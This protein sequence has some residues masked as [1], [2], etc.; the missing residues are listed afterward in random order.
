MEARKARK[1][2]NCFACGA[3]ARDLVSLFHAGTA[4]LRPQHYAQRCRQAA[5]PALEEQIEF[6]L[7]YFIQF[8]KTTL[9]NAPHQ[10]QI[11]TEIV[12]NELIAHSGNTFPRHCLMPRGH[13]S[14]E[15]FHRL[16][17]NFQIPN[18]RILSFAILKKSILPVFRIFANHLYRIANM[19]QIDLGILFQIATAS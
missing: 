10:L 19:C 14:R 4:Y 9:D 18:H 13:F 8:V 1:E 6:C 7:D 2:E 16:T 12:M 17:N 3:C 15:N 5:A 11:A